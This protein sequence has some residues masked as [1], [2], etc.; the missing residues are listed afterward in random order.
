M[1]ASEETAVYL[2]NFNSDSNG[3]KNDF[4][5]YSAPTLSKTHQATSAVAGT[6]LYI[7]I[8]L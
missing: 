7:I 8:G 2:L 3:N 1:R 6:N 5:I 4:I